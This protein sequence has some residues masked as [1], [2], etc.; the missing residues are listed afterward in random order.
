MKKA[1]LLAA[2]ILSTSIFSFAFAESQLSPTTDTFIEV[3]HEEIPCMVGI[4]NDSPA[5]GEGTIQFNTYFSPLIA[6]NPSNA[7]MIVAAMNQDWLTVTSSVGT[8][9]P[10]EQ[11]VSIAYSS[12]GG[13]SWSKQNVPLHVCLG[14]SL[15]N[16]QS[17]SALKYSSLGGAN[18]TVLMAGRFS[19]V[20]NESNYNSW[21]G[22]W[23]MRSVNGGATWINQKIVST[24]ETDAYINFTGTTDGTPALTFN[25][26]QA[27]N[28]YLAWDRPVY[29]AFP[30][31][32]NT[33]P[34]TGNIF[35]SNTN[36]GGAS[37]SD[38]VRI[39]NATDDIY[40][41]AQCSGVALETSV[42]SGASNR[43]LCSFMRSYRKPGTQVFDKTIDTTLYDRVVIGSTDGG[44]TWD[45]HATIVT[46]FVYAQSYSPTTTPSALPQIPPTDGA[47]KAHMAVNPASGRTY[48]L[49]QAGS[50]EIQDPA[51]GQFHPEIILSVSEDQ[52]K[53]WSPPVPVSRT[54]VSLLTDNPPAYQAFNGNIT[55]IGK[56]LIGILYYDY[57]NFQA[58]SDVASTDA[59]LAIYR[60]TSN[61]HSGSTYIGLDF[62]T[63]LRVTNPSFDSN[64]AT[65]NSVNQLVKSI[66]TTTGITSVDS[67]VLLAYGITNPGEDNAAKITDEEVFV[68]PDTY[69]A[70]VDVNNRISVKFQQVLVAQ[71]ATDKK[72]KGCH[73]SSSSSD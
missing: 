41:D 48:L 16:G 39:Y 9:R 38:P 73:S 5:N 19:N 53:V 10:R 71:T 34:V 44:L 31:F 32:E 1:S 21:A 68:D 58:G 37:W 42:K 15:S 24:Q 7:N 47:Q 60:E 36:N 28:A 3:D 35:F 25:P 27:S 22:I 70:S 56:D 63:E 62:V 20:L 29:A 66:G 6:V 72:H 26:S 2:C 46:P 59:W 54:P 64:I 61:V 67:S 23:T 49:W 45:K 12:T 52:G 43:L 57:R 17:V 30:G 4:I 18:G 13:N 65:N 33:I 55:V 69:K 11:E 51:V 14:G 50:Q 40:W 8:T